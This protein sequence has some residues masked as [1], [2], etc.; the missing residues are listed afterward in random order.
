MSD[1]NLLSKRVRR[2]EVSDLTLT[3]ELVE[4]RA[5]LRAL[6]EAVLHIAKRL[7]P[8]ALGSTAAD[9]LMTPPWFKN[10]P[11]GNVLPPPSGLDLQQAGLGSLRFKLTLL[12]AEQL[13]EF[14]RCQFRAAELMEK[15]RKR[16]IERAA[17]LK[18]D[19]PTL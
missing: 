14:H 11:T 4:V 13:A 3:E 5:S 15:L 6:Y 18:K 17:R 12:T 19:G 9:V 16:E 1:I 8:A 10:E 2:T 7:P